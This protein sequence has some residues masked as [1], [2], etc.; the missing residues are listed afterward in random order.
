MAF[1]QTIAWASRQLGPSPKLAVAG[2]V[3]GGGVAGGRRRGMAML[4]G[5]IPDKARRESAVPPIRDRG[6]SEAPLPQDRP[7]A[8]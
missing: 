2:A 1:A 8:E 6:R 5:V 4:K 3:A 7:P